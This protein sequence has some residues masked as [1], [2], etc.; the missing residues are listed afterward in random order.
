ME[1]FEDRE[2]MK[3]SGLRT[4]LKFRCFFYGKGRLQDIDVQQID[5][6]RHRWILLVLVDKLLNE[7]DDDMK[8]RPFSRVIAYLSVYKEIF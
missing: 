2:K 4:G 6:F 1:D 3:P 7:I 8:S 5:V